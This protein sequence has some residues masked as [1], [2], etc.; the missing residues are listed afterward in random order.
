MAK[1]A[2]LSKYLDPQV[3][4]YVAEQPL[5]PQG[6]VMGNLAGAHKSPLSGFAVEFSGHRE[7]V[8]GDDPRHIDWRVY[9]SR[10]KFF[11][12]QYEMETNFVCHLL[13]D[14]SKS[15]RYGDES[16][17]GGLS[18]F[19][20]AATTAASLAYLMQQQ[21]DAVGLVFFSTQVDKNLKPSSHPSH[22]KLMLHELEQV[23][24]DAETDVSSIFT[25]L[26]GQ[27]RQRGM[28]ILISDLFVD[29]AELAKTLERFRLRRHEVIVF[30]VMHEDELTFPFQENT[31]FRGLE[32]DVQ[33]HTE[34][35]AL[36]AS[37]LEAVERYM[38]QVRKVC[39]GLGVDHVL[40][41]TGKPLDAALSSYLAFRQ[42]RRKSLLRS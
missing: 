24:P 17:V 10:D 12:K 38:K 35:R 16:D 6:L 2:A 4:S 31:L 7:Y 41:N 37:Y 33:L 25:S 30:H 29:P 40:L 14:V 18:K 39:A 1:S 13:L 15:M 3:L 22:L 36:R 11:L 5:H 9:F 34:P 8:P 28:V 23:T 42:K 32:S 26:A 20:Y 19:D 27:V 21:Q